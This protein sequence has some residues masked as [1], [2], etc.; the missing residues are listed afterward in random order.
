MTHNYVIITPCVTICIDD[1][2]AFHPYEMP[3]MLRE[4]EGSTSLGFVRSHRACSGIESLNDPRYIELLAP[5]VAE[6]STGENIYAWG[7]HIYRYELDYGY[8]QLK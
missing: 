4:W 2:P 8:I 3:A 1:W 6:L 5:G 7:D